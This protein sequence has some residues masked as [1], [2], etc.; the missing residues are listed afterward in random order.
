[1]YSTAPAYWAFVGGVLLLSRDA[2]GVFYS[3]SLLGPHWRSLTSQKRC[4]W[5]IIQPQL[6]GPS[7]EE[8]Y[9]S[10]EMRLVYYTAPAYWALFGGV[11]RLSRDAVGVF[12]SSSL[13]G[14]RWRSLTPQQRCSLCILQPQPT[15][16]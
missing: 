13:L 12:Y 9:L 10:E 14:L 3:R 6:T 7:L 4:G 15:G 11:L 16:L 2:V 8:F 1:M 5:C